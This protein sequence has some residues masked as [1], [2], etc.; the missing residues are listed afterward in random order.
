MN[1]KQIT[2]EQ[3]EKARELAKDFR[4]QKRRDCYVYCGFLDNDSYCKFLGIDFNTVILLSD[5]E[6]MGYYMTYSR[7]AENKYQLTCTTYAGNAIPGLSFVLE[8]DTD[9][10]DFFTEEK[11]EEEKEKKDNSLEDFFNDN[12][13]NVVRKLKE[14]YPDVVA[15]IENEVINHLRDYDLD[16]SEIEYFAHE[17]MKKYPI[18]SVEVAEDYLDSDDKKRF[19][20]SWIDEI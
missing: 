16:S 13:G 2:T 14:M 6:D 7:A 3:I 9:F 1:R 17:Y 11:E 19:I 4:K 10:L 5:T 8:D 20:R 12:S 15:D 18:T